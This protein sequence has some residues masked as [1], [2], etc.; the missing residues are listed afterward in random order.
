MNKKNKNTPF[1][2]P[3]RNQQGQMAIFVA[4]IFQVL[5]V[6]FAMIINIAMVVHDKINLQNSV[7]L[8]AYYGAQKQAEVLNVIAHNNYMIR[9]SWKLLTYRYRAMGS[10][11][12]NSHPIRHN[13]TSEDAFSA[14]QNNPPPT[15]IQFK[16]WGESS[17]QNICQELNTNWIPTFPKAN[18]AAA[19]M[20][21]STIALLLHFQQER[22]ADS[23]SQSCDNYGQTNWLYA[24]NILTAYRLDQANR[25]EMI[26]GLGDNLSKK[27]FIEISGSNVAAGVKKTLEKNLTAENFSN[28]EGIE[29]YNSFEGQS[30][31]KWLKPINTWPTMA[32][33]NISPTCQGGNPIRNVKQPPGNLNYIR[34]RFGDERV[35]RL[36]QWA[37]NG[38]SVPES[39]MTHMSLSVEKNPWFMAYV[40]VKARTK[41]RQIFFPFGPSISFEATAFA[42]PFGGRIGP[43]HGNQWNAGEDKSSGEKVDALWPNRT[44]YLM[45]SAND[46]NRYVNHAK[47][48]GDKLGL[49]SNQGLNSV[50]GIRGMQNIFKFLHLGH[51]SD[52]FNDQQPNDILAWDHTGNSSPTMRNMEIAALSPDLFDTTYYSIMPN[53]TT[54]YLPSIKANKQALGLG[55]VIIRGDL[56]NRPGQPLVNVFNQMQTAKT[57]KNPSAG[58]WLRDVKHLLTGWASRNVLDYTFPDNVFGKC[59]VSTL[60]PPLNPQAA[61]G[62]AQGGRVGYSVKLVSKDYLLS[63]QHELGGV[64]SS[65]GAIMNP[66]NPVF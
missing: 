25:K 26:L 6:F 62:C 21:G 15:C 44:D 45:N 61:G 38:I 56:G 36:K 5:F 22:L 65:P 63:N 41:P 60:E 66:P 53:Y 57:Q 34:S 31:K 33:L 35:S 64:G 50:K 1:K 47:Y 8:A 51:I 20:T 32:Y 23:Y 14:A 30:S 4:L 19:I 3:L 17:S 12:L 13:V 28:I 43:W 9:Q 58:F 48:P 27:D 11:G 16:Q 39:Q 24:I 40:G 55:S 46:L 10:M 52:P 59:E 18:T 2:I 29:F 7:D 54:K 42:K 49:I 37:V